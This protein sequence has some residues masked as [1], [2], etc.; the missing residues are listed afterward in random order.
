MSVTTKLFVGTMVVAVTRYGMRTNDGDEAQKLLEVVRAHLAKVRLMGVDET[1]IAEYVRP[2]TKL[3]RLTITHDLRLILDDYQ[4]REVV[5]EPLNKA[6]YLLFLRHPGGI[7]FKS[8]SN[9]RQELHAIYM[10]VKDHRN[11]IDRRMK[12]TALTMSISKGVINTTNPLSNAINEKCTRIR[13]AFLQIVHEEVAEQYIIH[14][15][16]GGPKC[17]SLPRDMVTWE[18]FR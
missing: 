5:M 6:V 16:W 4:Q 18:H 11:D 9:Y 2:T 15:D 8:L 12:H 13:E 1:V 7:S 10:A 3:S 17:I 14:G